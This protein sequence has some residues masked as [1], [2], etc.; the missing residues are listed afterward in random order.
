MLC[1][2]VSKLPA[3]WCI[4][5]RKALYVLSRAWIFAHLLINYSVCYPHLQSSDNCKL[6]ILAGEQQSTGCFFTHTHIHVHTFFD[7]QWVQKV[8]FCKRLK[9][10]KPGRHVSIIKELM[11]KGRLLTLSVSQQA[12]W[13][14]ASCTSSW[15]PKPR[16]ASIHHIT[17]TS[18]QQDACTSVTWKCKHPRLV[19]HI[20]RHSDPAYSWNG[21]WSWMLAWTTVNEIWL[22]EAGRPIFT[23]DTNT[24]HTYLTPAGLW[25]VFQTLLLIYSSDRF[26]SSMKALRPSPTISSV[27]YNQAPSKFRYPMAR[28]DLH[29]DN[30]CL[31][32]W[33]RGERSGWV[34]LSC[35]C[36]ETRQTSRWNATSFANEYHFWTTVNQWGLPVSLIVRTWDALKSPSKYVLCYLCERLASIFLDLYLHGVFWNIPFIIYVENSVQW[37]TICKGQDRNVWLWL[38]ELVCFKLQDRILQSFWPCTI[39]CLLLTLVWA[40]LHIQIIGF[41]PHHFQGR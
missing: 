26:P 18:H 34:H 24:V 22:D 35:N 12:V 28:A 23:Q 36:Y 6:H 8:W 41:Y 17:F 14:K 2:P 30:T 20:N 1:K 9:V 32:S 33:V 5:T 11:L 19:C 39:T 37:D 29:R 15:F 13:Y 38:S 10:H 40:H 21:R 25:C 31:E 3:E 16:L 27:W 7:I 4:V